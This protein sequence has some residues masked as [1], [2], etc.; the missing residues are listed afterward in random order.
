MNED[1]EKL[2]EDKYYLDFLPEVYQISVFQ[3]GHDQTKGFIISFNVL[4]EPA[5]NKYKYDYITPMVN[6]D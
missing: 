2:G 3:Q 5:R 6:F 4:D 1:M